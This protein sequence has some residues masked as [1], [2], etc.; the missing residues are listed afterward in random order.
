MCSK[1]LVSSDDST[2]VGDLGVSGRSSPPR[3]RR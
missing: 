1:K 3:R 2:P